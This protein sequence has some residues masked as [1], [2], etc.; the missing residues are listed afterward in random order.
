[1]DSE[2]QSEDVTV[3]RDNYWKSM[4]SQLQS[5]LAQMEAKGELEKTWLDEPL[6][7]ELTATAASGYLSVWLHPDTG[8]GSWNQITQKVDMAEPWFMSP[9]GEVELSGE[10]MTLSEAVEQF[11]AKLAAK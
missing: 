9:E 6:P 8:K 2:L 1:M 10:K 4:V 3:A 7:N 11:A 5:V